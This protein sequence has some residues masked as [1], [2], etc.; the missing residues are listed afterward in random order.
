MLNTPHNR[1]VRNR[2]LSPIG[3]GAGRRQP[4]GLGVAGRPAGDCRATGGGV[5]YLRGGGVLVIR[6]NI[7]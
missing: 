5:R 3:Q 1:T 2:C 6:C 7:G 4:A